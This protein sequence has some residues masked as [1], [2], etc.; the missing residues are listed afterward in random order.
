MEIL[1]FRDS[2][3]KRRLYQDMVYVDRNGNYHSLNFIQ[4]HMTTNDYTRPGY[5]NQFE[6]LRN[7][8][9]SMR[10]LR[11]HEIRRFTYIEQKRLER[12]K[13]RFPGRTSQREPLRTQ[14]HSPGKKH[15]RQI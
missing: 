11:F 5:E 6:A 3:G 7:S 13:S 4:G 9:S 15:P 10:T 2:E 8:I 14:N 1:K 12:I